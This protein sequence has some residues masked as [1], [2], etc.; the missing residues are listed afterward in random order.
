MLN[1]TFDHNCIID[2]EKNNTVAGDL[3]KLIEL[4]NRRRIVL[5]VP[6]ISASERKPD[7]KY[8]SHF[9]EFKRRLSAIG[10]GDVEILPT[11]CREGLG[12]EGYTLECGG[13]VD[14]LEGKIQHIMFPATELEY[15]DFCKNQGYELN[16]KRAWHTWTNKKCD[17]LAIWSHIWH[18]GDIFVTSDKK[19]FLRQAKRAKLESLG[20]GK[21]LSPSEALDHIEEVQKQCAL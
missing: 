1:V 15:S 18:H 19:D 5:R 9:D 10:L 14:E 13:R 4:H 8:V 3:R 6:A 11:I 7:Q 21:I 12:F 20:A 16:D 17:V 2:L